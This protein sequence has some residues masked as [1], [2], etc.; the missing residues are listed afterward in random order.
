MANNPN[1]LKDPTDT[2]LTAIQE[3]L[4]TSDETTGVRIGAAIETETPQKSTIRQKLREPALSADRELEQRA[5]NDDRQ[6]IGQILQALQQRPPKTSYFIASIFALTW[7]ICGLT[8]AFLFLPDLRAV[9]RQGAAGVPAMIGLASFVLAPIAFFYVLANMVWRAQELRI[10]AQSMAGIALRL[11]EPEEVAHDSV[12]TVGQAIRREVAAMGDGV[13]R[14]LARATELDA[15]VANEVSALERAYNDNEVRMRGLLENL[16]RQ[17][18]TLVNQAEHVRSAISG[19]HLGLAN[20]IESVSEHVTQRVAE[21][22][23][24]IAQSLTEK[25]EHI[26]RALA[27]TGDSMIGALGERG[28]DLLERLEQTSIETTAAIAN[29]S[30]RLTSSLNFKTDHITEEFSAIATNLTRMMEGRLEEVTAGFS[31]RAVNVVRAM[32]DRTQQ[33][34]ETMLDTASRVAETIA[35]SGDEVNSTLKSTGES[36]VL[37]MSLRGGDVVSKLDQ[38]GTRITEALIAGGEKVTNTFHENAQN[39]ASTIASQGE[40]VRDLLTARL[41]AFE[42]MFTQGGAELANSVTRDTANLGDLITRHVAEFDRTVKTHGGEMIERLGQRA[43]EISGA[44]RVHIDDFDE[45]VGTK[46]SETA[47]TLGQ[48]FAQF[49]EAIDGRTQALNHALSSR[50]TE[51]AD[52]LAMGGKEVAATLDQ[53]STEASNN[54]DARISRFEQLL[55][56]RAIEVADQIE[57]RTKSAAETLNAQMEQLTSAIQ[58]NTASAS[59]TL[60]TASSEAERVL[61]GVGAEVARD[62]LEKANVIS[63]QVGERA[64]EMTQILDSSSGTLLS[65]LGGKSKEFSEEVGKA[66]D[67]AVKSIEAHGFTFSRTLMDN[68]EHLAR[69]INEAGNTATGSVNRTL[70][71]M[72]DTAQSAIEQSKQAAT[73]SVAEMRETHNTLRT[74]SITLFEGLR[75]ANVLLQEVL[76]GAHE[77][78]SVIEGTLVNRVSEFV[79]A[80][81]AVSERSGAAGSQLQQHTN[82]FQN[83]TGKVLTELGQ[84]AAHFDSHGRVLTEAVILLE[85]SNRRTDESLAER[86][87]SIDALLKL[88]DA[89]SDDIDQRLKGFSN[90]LDNSL[91]GAASRARDIVRIIAETGAEGV[92]TME[93]ERKRTGEQLHGIFAEHGGETQEI[94]AQ[95]TKR[96]SETLQSMKQMA[97]EV[98]RELEI[99]RNELRR[100]IFEIP[101]ET[102]ESTAQMRRV[103]VDQI[104]ALAELNR[105]VARHGR[106]LDAAEPGRRAAR[107]PALA[108]AARAEAPRMESSLRMDPPRAAGMA[109]PDLAGAGPLPPRRTESPS[110]GLGQPQNPPLGR[111]GW[112]SDLLHRASTADTGS[113]EEQTPRSE[114][115]PARHSLESLDSL[116][117]DIAR[118]IDHEAATEL[119]DRYKRGERNVFTRRLYTMQGQKTFDDIRKK[120]HSDYDFKQTVDRYI[121]EFERLLEE[122]ARDDRSQVMTRTYLTSET[123][124]VYTML[125]HAAGHFSE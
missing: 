103:I 14:A 33:I 21:S 108:P 10:I 47:N 58:S 88:L 69:V 100:G 4:R 54:L 110:L 84:L 41:A 48:N 68:S 67:Q 6:S 118:M 38:A 112:L 87:N 125:A 59:Q 61:L 81:N 79:T 78:M 113:S 13:E 76:T 40:S 49:Q 72:Q 19:M 16:A 92:R 31:Q 99:T 5:A 70:K 105:I 23:R 12:V 39:V 90:L 102:T 60:T 64:A 15:M 115:R 65:A 73:A 123:G 106:G 96:F 37:D 35:T 26:T 43:A 8:L 94:F 109:R 116:S 75:E 1:R 45:K 119:W 83:V 36:L 2:A 77:N 3:V 20:D 121:G 71:E 97:A 104:E 117:V 50:V 124:K 51:I 101:Q 56:G 114:E 32:E 22:T 63:Q 91:S 89:R 7:V 52:T 17:R 25:G 29:A 24:S 11:S 28:G 62:F 120:Y 27:H 82:A 34:T 111:S 80:M 30:D 93:E 86:R 98:Q 74:D 53:R 95:T 46:I 42:N 107:E 44:M 9:A 18:D 57:L 55:V 122:V 66:T 85:K